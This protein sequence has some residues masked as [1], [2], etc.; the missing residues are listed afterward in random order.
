MKG[1]AKV[2]LF[3]MI[4]LPTVANAGDGYKIT[5]QSGVMYFVAV[6]ADQKDNEDVYRYAVGEACAG[7]A[8]CQVQFWVDS[9]PKKFPLTDAQVDSKLV[10]WQLNLNTGLRRWLVKC[11]SSNLFAKERECM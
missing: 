2:F 10:Q 7:K 8:V 5:G 3:V 11:S 4:W 1:M 6:D 9:A